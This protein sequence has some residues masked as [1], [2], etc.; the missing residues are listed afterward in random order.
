[1][2]QAFKTS[3][4][5]VFFNSLLTK[6]FQFLWTLVKFVWRVFFSVYNYIIYKLE[7][8]YIFASIDFVVARKITPGPFMI[9]LFLSFYG[10]VYLGVVLLY[11]YFGLALFGWHIS[12]GYAVSIGV[13]ISILAIY[14]NFHGDL[15]NF[16]TFLLETDGI[17]K[18]IYENTEK[19]K[20]EVIV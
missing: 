7:T 16:K 6:V 9:G 3:L 18:G 14:I 10:L 15:A 2:V 20:T 13:F 5:T 19:K 11:L 17:L 4:T 12:G 1:M 8:R